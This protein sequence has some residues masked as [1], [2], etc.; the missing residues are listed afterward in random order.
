MIKKI[1]LKSETNYK[2]SYL[3]DLKFQNY[4]FIV[5]KRVEYISDF[6]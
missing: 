2:Y 6:Y 5:K 1:K 3:K 4:V